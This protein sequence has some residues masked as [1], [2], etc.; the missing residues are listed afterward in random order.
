MR[1]GLP[2]VLER[3][4]RSL[5]V[6]RRA[7]VLLTI[8]LVVLAVYAALLSASL[9]IEHRRGG[10]AMLRSRGAGRRGIVALALVE[11]AAAHHPGCARRAVPG[12]VR[13]GVQPRRAAG[14]DRARDRPG[15][16]TD[17]FVAAAAGARGLPRRADAAGVPA[18]PRSVARSTGDVA[19]GGD[20]AIGRRLG[21]DI[22]LLAVA[23]IGLWQLRLYGAPLTRSVQGALG[24]DPLLVAA[25]GDRAP[26]RRGRRPPVVPLLARSLER[27]RPARR[28]LV[29][30]LGARQLARRP[31][32]YTRAALLLMLAMAMGVFAVSYTWTWT[33]SQQDQATFQVG[34]DVRVSPAD[35]LGSLPRWALDGAYAGV[36][37]RDRAA[38]RSTRDECRSAGPASTGRLLAL[39]AAAAP[40]IVH[41]R[42]DLSD[43][44]SPS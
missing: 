13:P 42:P 25:P 28:G 11:G 26:G 6:S 16:T 3:T 8:Q 10:T 9:L 37:G 15:V 4:E 38:C 23:A 27:R 22:A 32:R 20:A 36:P 14:R 40:A 39:D 12:T 33:A 29:P 17:A 30:S 43:T 5:L 31:L 34:A 18:A 24:L 1:S 44:P 7:G 41:L 19:R 21:I 35:Q 2:D